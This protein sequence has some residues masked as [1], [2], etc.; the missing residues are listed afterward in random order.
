M[1]KFKF[2]PALIIL[3]L[4]VSS[5]FGQG[6]S[7][8]TRNERDF[9]RIS[10]GISGNLYVN[11]GPEFKVVL[12]GRNDILREVE[13]SVTG[14]RLVIRQRNWRFSMRD[15][16]V[17]AYVTMPSI[18]GLS[19]SGSGRAEIKDRVSSDAL[20]LS[21][22]GS[23]KIYAG[24]VEVRNLNCSI[25]GSGDI[26]LEGRGEARTAEIGIS[27]SGN[28]AGES[29]TVRDLS[30]RISGSGSCYCKVSE[31]LEASISGSGNIT[32]AGSPRINARVSGSG[33]VRSR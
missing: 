1:S 5:T 17:T 8:E 32:Y 28:Y 20:S 24:D 31:T 29:F 6:T 21:V 23:G 7:R 30:A 25:S 26:V 11:I 4:S 2:C 15:Q 9:T 16:R 14:G 27:G 10:Y 12:E 18:D 13:T 3:L 22:S 19:V 33:R